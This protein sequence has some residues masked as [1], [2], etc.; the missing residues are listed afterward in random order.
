MLYLGT[1][2]SMGNNCLWIFWFWL[3][4][5]YNISSLMAVVWIGYVCNYF[6]NKSNFKFKFARD[7]SNFRLLV[8]DLVS[9]R[10]AKHLFIIWNLP[11]GNPVSLGES[12]L[13]DRACGE[14][15]VMDTVT[16]S[17]SKIYY[18]TSWNEWTFLHLIFTSLHSSCHHPFLSLLQRIFRLSQIPCS[19]TFNK[20]W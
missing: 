1:L 20:F 11:L 15:L 18:N 4:G 7:V 3:C 17:E 16:T 14:E 12:S 2:R 13:S 9:E 6:L 5:I 19:S 10:L 8:D